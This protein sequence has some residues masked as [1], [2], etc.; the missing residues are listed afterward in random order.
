MNQMNLGG[1]AVV[2]PE[3]QYLDPLP[4]HVSAKAKELIL[5]ITSHPE[6]R[7][8]LGIKKLKAGKGLMSF[9]L[10]VRYRL[11]VRLGDLRSGPYL[12]MH[13]DRYDRMC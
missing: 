2:A 1:A 4:A 13:H 11:L 10:N 3:I 12:C 8:Q 7:S 5:E 6:R 9:R